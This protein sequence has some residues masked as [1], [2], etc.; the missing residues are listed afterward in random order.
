MKLPR[1]LSRLFWLLRNTNIWQTL[2][3]NLS[4]KH[5]RSSRLH[6]Y[7]RSQIITA[8][9]S[10]IVLEPSSYLV[11]CD[12]RLPRPKVDPA[13]LYLFQHANLKISGFV[14]VFEGATIVVFEGGTLEIGNRVN[15]NRCTIQCACHIRIGNFCRIANDVL[16]Q[17]TDF[18][19]TPSSNDADFSGQINIEDCVWVCPKAT[20]LKGVT[21][22]EGAIVAAGAVVT[23][24]VPPDCLVAGVPAKIVKTNIH[25]WLRDISYPSV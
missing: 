13:L 20:I 12:T 11:I 16:I 18:H 22:G 1:K 10:R 2:T 3:L 6:V 8:K 19:K 4:V 9:T 23:K 5:P 15:I 17:D 21:I 14:T 7:H 25:S 24:D